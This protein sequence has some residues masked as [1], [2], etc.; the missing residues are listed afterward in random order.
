LALVWA[1]GRPRE[2]G[3][4]AQNL[5]KDDRPAA[6]GGFAFFRLPDVFTA[7]HQDENE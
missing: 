1:G 5:P 6:L 7:K 2:K 4:S 3:K